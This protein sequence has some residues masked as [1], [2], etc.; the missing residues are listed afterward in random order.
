MVYVTGGLK[1]TR[2]LALLPSKIDAV[3]L[4]RPV[5]AKSPNHVTPTRVAQMCVTQ[6]TLKL[7]NPP[8]S[9]DRLPPRLCALP[10]SGFRTLVSPD[11]FQHSQLIMIE[12]EGGVAIPSPV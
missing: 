7:V 5:T 3:L 4:P 1:F 8:C 9:A 6:G 10:Q 11:L 12:C 2:A